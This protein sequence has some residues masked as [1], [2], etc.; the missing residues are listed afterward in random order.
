MAWLDDLRNEIKV[1]DQST[2]QEALERDHGTLL[3]SLW[4]TTF[5]SD[6][7]WFHDQFW[8]WILG[9]REGSRPKKPLV[10]LVF[11]GGGKTTSIEAAVALLAGRKARHHIL[12]CAGTQLVANERIAGI[13][14]KLLAPGFQAQ[15]PHVG[16]ATVGSISDS[17]Q[18][19][20]M[21]YVITASGFTVHGIGLDAAIRSAKAPDDFRPD[22]VALDDVDKLSDSVTEVMRKK[23]IITKTILPTLAVCGTVLFAQNMI[24]TDSLA[25]QLANR[26]AGFLLD[27]DV[28]G[29][30]KAA[31]DLTYVKRLEANNQGVVGEVI[32]VTGGQA[33]WNHFDLEA[34]Q[35][36]INSTG[37]DSFLRESQHDV[38]R[39]AEGASF[40]MYSESHS[41]I[42][43]EQFAKFFGKVAR[44][45]NGSP[46]LPPVGYI[47]CSLD[48]GT[49][50]D[51]PTGVLWIWRPEKGMALDDS[52]FIYR[53]LVLPEWP[54]PETKDISP[55]VVALK[56]LAL[57]KPWDE[58]ARGRM[59]H[60]IMSHEAK[61]DRN[62]FSRDIVHYQ[63][64]EYPLGLPALRFRAWD[65]HK[66][67]GIG[68]LQNYWTVIEAHQPH[69]MHQTPN[70]VDCHWTGLSK[71][72]P[73]NPGVDGRVRLYG[74]VAEDQRKNP[75]SAAGLARL[76]SEIVKHTGEKLSRPSAKIFDDLID[77]ARFAAQEFF[78][79]QSKP[80]E[81]DLVEAAL[82]EAY[83]ADATI[84]LIAALNP[85][86]QKHYAST[87]YV[88]QAKARAQVKKNST[89]AVLE[90]YQ[91]TIRKLRSGGV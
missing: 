19:W 5:G 64:E 13:K 86:A 8:A 42:T 56:I 25:T 10:Y 30:V 17:L 62:A 84:E 87:Q 9:I 29:P 18:R 82:P 23:N 21:D 44:D 52:F 70:G 7:A 27:A 12:Y 24:H 71:P 65:S 1:E 3:P 63:T 72:N 73:F 41:I 2:V 35:A 40:P 88:M 77:P 39:P 20:S 51:H 50:P 22:L 28:I 26:S 79:P 61:S 68:L 80:R 16:S 32:D 58:G 34:I 74:V 60:R 15:Y 55:L 6:F 59:H 91:A 43:W 33:N 37:L 66:T 45:Q 49:S 36:T 75:Y 11:R 90:D 67:G 54:H 46:R 69:C 81:D 57:E 85:E 89:T 76:R 47:C 38:D 48:W 78:V 4:P 31:E 14:N 83:R 53:E